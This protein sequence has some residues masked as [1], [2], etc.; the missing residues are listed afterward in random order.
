MPK[1][2]TQ[3]FSNTYSSNSHKSDY[4]KRE[5]VAKMSYRSKKKATVKTVA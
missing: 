4:L 3:T 1:N 2:I 5:N